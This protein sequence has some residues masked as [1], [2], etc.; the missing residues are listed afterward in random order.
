MQIIV[1]K[2]LK[3][4]TDTKYNHTDHPIAE[5]AFVD[6]ART[7]VYNTCHVK[8]KKMTAGYYVFFY[9]AKFKKDQLCRKLNVVLHS[10][11]DPKRYPL[12]RLDAK[13][14]GSTFLETLERKNFLRSCQGSEYV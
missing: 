7:D 13:E 4:P 3:I 9:T 8:I 11:H 2:V 5:C 1:T 6:G 12:R 10:P 14:F